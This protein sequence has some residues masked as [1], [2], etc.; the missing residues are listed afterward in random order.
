MKTA[1]IMTVI[2]LTFLVSILSILRI[3]IGAANNPPGFTYLAVGHYYLDY[4]EYLQQTAQGVMGHWTVLNQFATDDPTKTILGWGQYLIIG[5]IA[6]I[7]HLSAITGYWFGVFFLVFFFSLSIYF[8]I[9][10]LLPNLNFFYQLS[11]WFFCLFAAP[12]FKIEVNNG[13]SKIVPYDFWYAP[14]SFFHRFGGIPHHLSTGILTVII[15]LMS[16]NIFDRLKTEVLSKIIWKIIAVI[17]LLLTLL[18]FGPLQVINIISS[19]FLVGIIFCIKNKPSKN[20]AYF[21]IL[22]VLFILPMAW[23]IKISHD[24]GSLFQ[25]INIWEVSQENH[26]GLLSIILTTGPILIFALLGL[27]RFFKDISNIR[28]ILLFYVISSYLFFSTSLARFFGTFNSRFL[29]GSVYV[30]FGT[31]A[32]LGVIE[33]A[34]WFG[35]RKKILTISLILLL[36]AYFFWITTMIY[37]S[38]GSVDQA[39]YLPNSIYNGMQFLGNQSDKRAVLTTPDKYFGVVVPVFADKNVYIARPMFTPDFQNRLNIADRFF[40]GDMDPSEAKKFVNDNKIGFVF[41][42]FMENYQPKNLDK[43]LFLNKIYDKEGVI[44]FKVVLNSYSSKKVKVPF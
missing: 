16:A 41:I 9:K 39:S 36:L 30:L 6:K 34:D 37:Q 23:L 28:W 31:L 42:T 22:I 14:M 17:G 38:F 35:K 43:Y 13:I 26:P 4:F 33:I 1:K 12:F 21:L 2:N 15:L 5:K 27:R 3:I 11:A 8:I 18:T 20:L 10:R 44:I 25:R 19:I 29:S 32:I 24:N 7:F 40:R